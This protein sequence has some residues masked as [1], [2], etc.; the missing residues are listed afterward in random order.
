MSRPER[1][2]IFGGTFDPPHNGHIGAALAFQR[3][4]E[5]DSLLIMPDCIPPHKKVSAADDPPLRLEMAHAA[6]DGIS[7][8][9][10]VSDYEIS[11]TGV[12]YTVDTL[13]HFTK[14]GRKIFLL[15]GTDMFLSLASWRDPERIFKL[16]TVVG[17]P[18]DLDNRGS[19][20]VKAEEYTQTYGARCRILDTVPFV[21]SSSL[22]RSMMVSGESTDEYIPEKVKTIIEREKLYR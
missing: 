12:S 17:V 21:I 22:L 19:L 2:G 18:R 3:E 10:T 9:I 5:L 16:A 7:D 6:F 14:P 11:K 8:K 15:C 1:F 13:E 4:I 20:F